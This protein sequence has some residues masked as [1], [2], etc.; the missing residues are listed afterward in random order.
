MSAAACV[1]CSVLQPLRCSGCYFGSRVCAAVQ[2]AA[3]LGE[4]K[5]G[6]SHYSET[7]EPITPIMMAEQ[8]APE[9]LGHTFSGG[10]PR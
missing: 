10:W 2:S 9:V 8:K 7:A 4:V 3:E 5:R 1:F 6:S